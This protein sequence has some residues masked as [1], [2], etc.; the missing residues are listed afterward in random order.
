M[1]PPVSE[2]RNESSP[3]HLLCREEPCGENNERLF[4]FQ[5][6]LAGESCWPNHPNR[7]RILALFSTFAA[8]SLTPSGRLLCPNDV[9]AMA[10]PGVVHSLRAAP[11]QHTH[12]FHLDYR[13][14]LLSRLPESISPRFPFIPNTAARRSH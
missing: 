12:V 2:N 13:G 11:L 8:E 5:G 14:C 1:T 7:S 4:P 10:P 6:D 3:H 9:P